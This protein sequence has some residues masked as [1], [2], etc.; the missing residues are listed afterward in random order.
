MSQESKPKRFMEV[1]RER[2][3]LRHLSYTT[4]LGTFKNITWARRK[5]RVPEVM[6]RDEVGRVLKALARHTQKWL[7]ACLMY[8]C[9]LRLSEALRLG[10][11]DVEFGQGGP[12]K[13]LLPHSP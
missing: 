12:C 2:I 13:L 4:D 6:T 5:R 7:I 3:R 11:K 1:V 8:G 10:V 9:G